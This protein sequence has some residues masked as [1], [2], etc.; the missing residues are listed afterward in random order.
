MDTDGD[1]KFDKHTVFIDKL[2]L[3]RI[4]LLLD[5]RLI[6]GEF[7]TLDLYAYRDTNGD[8]VADEKT[9]LQGRTARWESGASAERVDLEHG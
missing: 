8:G 5:D 6:V 9:P 3:P 2:L 4:L 7:N 1:G